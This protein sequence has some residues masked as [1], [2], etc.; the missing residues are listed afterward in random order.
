MKLICTIGPSS[1]GVIERMLKYCDGVRLNLKHGTFEEHENR[2]KKIREFEEKN[3]KYIPIIGDI[4]GVEI[5]T[6]REMKPIVAKENVIVTFREDY[7]VVSI[8]F[9]K[10]AK[11]VKEGDIIYIDDGKIILKIKEKVDD[12]TFN[13]DVI[14]GGIIEPNKSVS[15]P[16]TEIEL[17]IFENK[18]NEELIRFCIENDIDQIAVS[19]IQNALQ[20]LEVREFVKRKGGNQWIMSKIEHRSA[21]KHLKEIV[22][23][24]DS[25]M[26]ARGDLAV[27]VGFENLPVVQKE[28]ID[29][30]LKYVKPVYIAT[31]FLASM[32]ERSYPTRAE[33]SD[34]ANSILLGADGIIL[35]NET[36]VGKYPLEAAKIARRVLNNVSKI[37]EENSKVLS[38]DI[39]TIVAK[40]AINISKELENSIIVVETETG[41]SAINITRFRPKKEIIAITPN[42]RV[43]RNVSILYGIRKVIICPE[44]INKVPNVEKLEKLLNK[45][46][47]YVIYVGSPVLKR[48]TTMIH[49]LY[50]D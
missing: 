27:E 13:A 34:I 23:A 14:R 3:N 17:S 42:K 10:I 48:K 8:P 5:R 6:Y 38:K 12:Y 4:P 33:V 41:Y 44:M 1:E 43:A 11:F 21:L 47:V 16:D 19:F 40:H 32:I 36:A 18:K 15:F 31:E 22:E 28:I 29:C 37:V 20:V 26:I 2:I 46:K 39:S 9:K 24:S 49:I 30:S 35:T 45:R 25:I 50:L 7:D